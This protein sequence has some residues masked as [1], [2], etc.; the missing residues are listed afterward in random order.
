MLTKTILPERHTRFLFFAGKGGVGKSTLSA[1]TAIWLADQG[2]RTLLVSTD[3]QRS[4]SDLFEREIGGQETAIPEVPGLTV[5]ETDPERLVREHWHRLAGA[6]QEAFGPSELLE[7]MSR[8][9]SPCMMEMASFYFLLELYTSVP[10]RFQAIVFDTA[11]GGR[12]LVEIRLPFT[13]AR[14]QAQG[15]PFAAFRTVPDAVAAEIALQKERTQETLRLLTD[16]DHTTFLYV[17]WPESL[18]IAETERA[19][20]EL[21]NHGI[22]V[23]ILVVNELLP[24]EEVRRADTD[25]FWQRHR[26]QRKH[27]STIHERF[28]GRLIAEVPLW[29]TEVKGVSRLRELGQ[30]LYEAESQAEGGDR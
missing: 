28:S 4:L 9:V 17:L 11:P 26:M 19:I 10:E 1:A 3:L 27:Y 20:G 13:L 6:V 24:E 15:D 16:P 8:E 2:H 18:P 23:P 22:G 21:A 29:P 25:Y 5:R 12:A 30:Q 14:R 7:L